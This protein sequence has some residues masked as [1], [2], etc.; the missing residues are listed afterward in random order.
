MRLPGDNMLELC[1]EA[2]SGMI[3]AHLNNTQRLT[4]D[5]KIRVT[6][7]HFTNNDTLQVSLT[8]DPPEKPKC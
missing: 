6:A 3:E 2:I 7:I 8:T 1:S 4:N 5:S